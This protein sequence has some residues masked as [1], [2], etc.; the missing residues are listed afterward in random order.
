MIINKQDDDRVGLI[1]IDVSNVINVNQLHYVLKENL[2][3]PDFYGMNWDAF[4]DAITG[5]AEMPKKLVL[6]G[7]GNV[8]K[9]LPNDASLMKSLLEKLNAKHPSWSCEVDYE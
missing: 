8:E 1:T 7:W 4:W 2:G 9:I 3:F 6:I 5:L